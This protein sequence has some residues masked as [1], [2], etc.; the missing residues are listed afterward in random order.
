M[1][2]TDEPKTAFVGSGHRRSVVVLGLV[3]ASDGGTKKATQAKSRAA[4]QLATCH[5]HGPRSAAVHGL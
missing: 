4:A 2:K 3:T 1:V 5:D